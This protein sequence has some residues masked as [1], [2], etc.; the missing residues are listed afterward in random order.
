MTRAVA[1]AP[2]SRGADALVRSRPPGRLGIAADLVAR[3][4][5]SSSNSGA[6]YQGTASAVPES[7]PINMAFRP[8]N[9]AISTMSDLSTNF[10]DG[11]LVAGDLRGFPEPRC[12][13]STRPSR[14]A[15]A[16]SGAR[17]HACR[18]GNLADA[19]RFFIPVRLEVG[20]T[21]GFCRLSLLALT[22]HKR[23]WPVPQLS[24]YFFEE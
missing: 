7:H 24:G 8:C 20:Q 9:K 12:G 22:G 15:P 18:V 13:L 2:R 10:K 1:P 14:C 6:L 5:S 19:R 23:R 4:T 11:T 3:I 21:I 16:R 17:T